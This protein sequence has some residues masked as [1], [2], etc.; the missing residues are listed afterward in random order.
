MYSSII[1][2]RH[3][4][5]SDLFRT[6]LLTRLM[7]GGPRT[8]P[9]G[10]NKW[11]WK[12]LHEKRAKEKEKRLLEQE[13]QL[14]Q[15]RIRSQIRANI[16]GG[17]NKGANTHSHS[18]MSPEDHI[19]AL[20]D[21]F[22]KEGA[23]DLW[24]EKDGP[25]KLPPPKPNRGQGS[26]GLNQ[27]RVAVN[28]PFDLR[29]LMP[30]SSN[31]GSNHEN[32]SHG[33][34]WS[35]VRDYSVG[36]RSD[37]SPKSENLW[38]KQRRFRRNESSSSDDDL[39][40]GFVYN[41]VKG[42][43]GG[44]EGKRDN[45]KNSINV[46]RYISSN[47]SSAE[48]NRGFQSNVRSLSDDG[49]SEGT[50]SE[51]D[52]MKG[53]RGVKQIGSRAALGNYDVKRTKRVPLKK[54]EEIDFAEEVESIRLELGRKKLVGSEEKKGVEGADDSI[55]SNKRFDE[56]GISPM[57]VK[58]LSAAGYVQMTRVQEATLSICLEGKDAI[59]KAKTGTGKTAA[60]LL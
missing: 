37:F 24:N 15:A 54:L 42:F 7:G 25:L 23:E 58:A 32:G 47:S 34:N 20:A 21:R 56:C 57:T 28:S 26:V 49:D 43:A 10:I 22:V 35:K 39:D 45:A 36:R 50:D 53:G 40:Y 2:Q 29:K 19:K 16:A 44:S 13:K 52:R 4:I 12:R 9:G 5:V 55:L 8:F 31:V 27:R 3:R 60:F 51:D 14:Y 30:E 38:R 41:S 17:P 46:S 48:K 1:L 18:P 33:Y 59:V 11:Q 6:R